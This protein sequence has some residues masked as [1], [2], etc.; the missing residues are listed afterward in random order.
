MS[1][2]LIVKEVELADNEEF[3]SRDDLDVSVVLDPESNEVY[4]RFSGFENEEDS[5]EYAQFLSETLPLLLFETTRL[6]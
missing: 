1:K 4:V 6:Q 5:A 3:I 2:K